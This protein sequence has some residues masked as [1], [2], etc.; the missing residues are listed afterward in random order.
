MISAQTP[1]GVFRE[2]KPLHTFPDRALAVKRFTR[3]AAPCAYNKRVVTH[4]QWPAV[5][6][7]PVGDGVTAI[8]P[9]IAA[10][11]LNPGR[12]LP[13]FVFGNIEQPIDPR[14]HLT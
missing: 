4:R 5:V 7:K 13:S 8:A 14:H 10:R 11:H 3:S 6:A 12:G 9:E 1:S 2:G